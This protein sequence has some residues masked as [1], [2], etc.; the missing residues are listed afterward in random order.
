[1][2]GMNT[3]STT[4]EIEREIGPLGE[5]SHVHVPRPS[6]LLAGNLVAEAL[7]SGDSRAAAGCGCSRD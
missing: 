7:E 6:R 4:D 3:Y 1:M 2:T 5:P